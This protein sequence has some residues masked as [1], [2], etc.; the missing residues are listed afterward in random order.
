MTAAW[1][2]ATA[3]AA[4]PLADDKT[5]LVFAETIGN[6]SLNVVDVRAWADAAHAADL[7]LVVDNTLPS[8]FLCR[9]FD[10]G[11]DVDDILADLQSA[12]A[13]ARRAVAV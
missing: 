2:E 1:P 10:L 3:T 8:P 9:V 7:P 11:A 6:P 4:T 13:R 12:L 5:R